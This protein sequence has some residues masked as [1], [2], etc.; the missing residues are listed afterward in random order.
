ME[1]QELLPKSLTQLAVEKLV[2]SLEHS[3]RRLND[4]T[5]KELQ[6]RVKTT[7]SKLKTPMK[8]AATAKPLSLSNIESTKTPRQYD[9]ETF[10]KELQELLKFSKKNECGISPHDAAGCT[11][12]ALRMMEVRKY[13]MTYA[14]ADVQPLLL[15]E[16]ISKAIE[17]KNIPLVRLVLKENVEILDF[18]ALEKWQ[19]QK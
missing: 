18:R 16:V 14:K 6:K 17:T 1:T 5:V 2:G 4:F 12:A 3:I 10:N 19:G 9:K 7:R 8:E 15:R 11:Q 13:I